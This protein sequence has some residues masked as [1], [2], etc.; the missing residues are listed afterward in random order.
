M[1]PTIFSGLLVQYS[2]RTASLC[3]E[4]HNTTR[5]LDLALGVFAEVT[6]ANDERYLGDSALA[7]DFA[8]AE[9]EEVEDGCSVGGALVG[10]VLFALLEGNKRPELF[11]KVVNI[12]L[13]PKST[14]FSC[15]VY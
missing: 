3:D 11:G 9:G 10:E 7:E 5:L 14:P 4:L 8:V 2:K 12:T 1:V 6:C 15:V 13:F